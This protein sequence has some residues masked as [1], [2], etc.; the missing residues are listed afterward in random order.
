[1][2][3]ID[4]CCLGSG[5]TFIFIAAGDSLLVVSPRAVGKQRVKVLSL[6]QG[7]GN[8]IASIAVGYNGDNCHVFAAFS[9]KQLCCWDAVTGNVV[10]SAAL[11]KAPT[12]L[13]HGTF[14]G[15]Q[16][17]S[18][19]IFETVTVSDKAGD[20]YATD[21]PLLKKQMLIGGHTAS[22]ITDLALYGNMIATADR[23]EKVRVSHY[24]N[25]HAITS[26]CLGHTSVVSSVSFILIEKKIVLVSS[27]WD[28]KML[29]WDPYTGSQ[30]GHHSFNSTENDPVTAE[31]PSVDH[32]PAVAEE[33]FESVP[34][35]GGGGADNDEENKNYDEDTAGN[36]PLRIIAAKTRPL[37]AVVFKD[38]TSVKLF[39]IEN[40][41]A[42]DA[43]SFA[44]ETAI[45]QPAV[46]CDCVFINDDQ[47]LL[48]LL[49]SPHCLRV[50]DVSVV[51]QGTA[52][53]SKSSVSSKDSAEFVGD[54]TESF[55][56]LQEVID[57]V[58]E[59]G[60]SLEQKSI[61]LGL[62]GPG[63]NEGTGMIKRPL[64]KPFD[65]DT[66]IKYDSRKGSKRSRKK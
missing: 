11:K 51:M 33:S 1:M 56:A 12:A 34:V 35:E 40:S 10:G 24:P 22:V 52:G 7:K 28:H 19:R 43:Y 42:A 37:A 23:D 63:G 9:N 25:T 50:Y 45:E 41:N 32:V 46:A 30:V 53:N 5:E 17:S 39:S 66:D 27:G 57:A 61:S 31:N 6:E 14:D 38:S 47:H 29:L 4:A 55:S 64:N 48:V 62:G 36:F 44:A 59:L 8:D 58:A 26:Y 2:R 49:P 13:V 20:L 65:K 3:L 16:E 18:D 21:S 60:V 15:T 54:I